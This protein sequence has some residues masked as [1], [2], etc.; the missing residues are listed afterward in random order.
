MHK[1]YKKLW[2]QLRILLLLLRLPKLSDNGDTQP[3]PPKQ[4]TRLDI[5]DMNPAQEAYAAHDRNLFYYAALAD[6]KSG[7]IYTD[8]PGRFPVA[9]I[10]NVQYISVRYAYEPNAILVRPPKSRETECMVAAY[11]DIYEY[12]TMK[13]FKPTMNVTDNKCSKPIQSYI[14]SQ[15]VE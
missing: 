1:L 12:L 5:Q 7:V 9:S 11:K 2:L 14:A 15:D 13:K 3:H 6:A 4:P 10:R 8:L